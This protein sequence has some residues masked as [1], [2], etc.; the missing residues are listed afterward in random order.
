MQR[1]TE[2]Y[3]N[4]THWELLS[5]PPLVLKT[6]ATTR[7]ANTSRSANVVVSQRAPSHAD[8]H[9]LFTDYL[10]R[11]QIEENGNKREDRPSGSSWCGWPSETLCTSLGNR[12]PGG[13][14]R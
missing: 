7:G 1:T 6:R 10:L 14:I 5:N 11:L 12:D 3:G 9:K 8:P 4:R 2:V 13:I